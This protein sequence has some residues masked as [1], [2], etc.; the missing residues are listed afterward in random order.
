MTNI[1]EYIRH[2]LI[3]APKVPF[4]GV[5]KMINSDNPQDNLELTVL[6]TSVIGPKGLRVSITKILLA[7]QSGALRRGV[8][9]DFQP[10]PSPLIAVEHL[11]LYIQKLLGQSVAL[12]SRLWKSR[13]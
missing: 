2:T 12:C 4:L 1:F 11:S 3:W 6:K 9:R 7:P 13:S 5:M 8:Y 10:I